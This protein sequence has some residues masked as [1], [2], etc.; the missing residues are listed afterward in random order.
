MNKQ[1]LKIYLTHFVLAVLS[2]VLFL[3]GI[4]YYLDSYTKH[5]EYIPTPNVLKLPVNQAIEEITKHHL[6]YK[7]IDSIYQP[8]EKPGIVISQ[9][10]DPSTSVKENRVIYLTITSFQPPQIEMPKLVDLSER[11]ALM[12]LKSYDLKLGK[13]TYEE[14]YCNGCVVKQ[15]YKGNYIEP[16]KYIKKGSVIDLVIGQ[17]G[18]VIKNDTIKTDENSLENSFE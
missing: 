7:I 15:L 14:A 18:H 3:W 8:N 4:S 2:V 12:I 10:P 13:I 1:I 9:N 17:K 6:R 16:G 5:G 11:Q